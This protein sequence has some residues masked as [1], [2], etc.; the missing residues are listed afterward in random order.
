MND[1]LRIS[2]AVTHANLLQSDLAVTSCPVERHC[3]MQN[4]TVGI[5]GL[6]N[7]LQ[8]DDI[9]KVTNVFFL[10]KGQFS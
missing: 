3:V 4:F 6:F 5:S 8:S 1:S 7:F 10:Q 2:D 9:L